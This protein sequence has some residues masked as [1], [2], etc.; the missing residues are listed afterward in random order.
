[1]IDY[2]IAVLLVLLAVFALG[3]VLS[4]LHIPFLR[5]A[6]SK[7]NGRSYGFYLGAAFCIGFLGVFIASLVDGYFMLSL[8]FVAMTLFGGV[9]AFWNYIRCARTLKFE[10]EAK[11]EENEKA[12]DGDQKTKNEADNCCEEIDEKSKLDKIRDTEIC[13]EG[14]GCYDLNAQNITINNKTKDELLCLWNNIVYKLS[15]NILFVS[16]VL[17]VVL[18]ISI[19]LSAVFVAAFRPLD[20]ELTL[21]ETLVFTKAEAEGN[22]LFLY[23]DDSGDSYAVFGYRDCMD[24]ADEFIARVGCGGACEVGFI[25]IKLD[26]RLVCNAVQS[27]TDENGVCLLTAE[28]SAETRNASVASVVTAFTVVNVALAVVDG[29]CLGMYFW[30]RGRKKRA[31]DGK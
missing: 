19:T 6:G 1:M 17:C 16:V 12:E 28:A 4:H 25:P 11:I 13:G 29:L 10:E 21:N 23:T 14:T 20:S 27:L 22:V 8:S 30:Q 26:E 5:R 3:G 24:A 31:S 18:V 9:L 7:D 15:K 2:I